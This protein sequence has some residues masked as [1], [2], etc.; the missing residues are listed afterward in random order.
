MIGEVILQYKLIYRPQDISEDKN[1]SYNEFLNTISDHTLTTIR[2]IDE[3][4]GIV[5]DEIITKI[6][7]NE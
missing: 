5:P 4:A 6:K 1:I 3:I 2:E 7:E